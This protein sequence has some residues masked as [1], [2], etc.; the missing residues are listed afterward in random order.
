MK[1]LISQLNAIL[2]LKA[3]TR[4]NGKVASERTKTAIGD[5]LRASFRHLVN[6][7]FRLQNPENLG[8]KHVKALCEFWYQS[9][10]TPKTIQSNLSYLRIFARW[11]GKGEMVKNV[12]H[13]LPDVP[14][15]KLRVKTAAITSKSWAENGIDVREKIREA[16]A[17]DRRFGAMLRVAVAFGLRRHE[18]IECH[19]WKVDRGDRFAAYKTKGGRPRDIYIDTTEQRIVLDQVKSMV[20]KSEHLGWTTKHDGSVADIKFS[21]GKWHRMLAKIGITKAMTK[22][23]GHGLRAQFAENAALIASVIPPTLG[24]GPGQMLKEDLDLRRE[25]AS[26]QLGHSRKSITSAYYGSFGRD[27]GPDPVDRTKNAIAAAVQAIPKEELSPDI[28]SSRLKDC[29]VLT[30]ELMAVKAYVDPRVAHFL[31]EFHSSRHGTD[32]L[33][34]GPQNIAALEAASNHFSSRTSHGSLLAMDQQNAGR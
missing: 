26:E 32:W 19:P 23:T 29:S 9:G 25:Q 10:L 6:L 20:K 15:A 22:V 11:I 21:L 3:G 4:V 7:N 33:S 34:L 14:R 13:Y 2:Q 17:L 16:D 1:S 24:G 30:A 28:P 31:W 18:V 5:S 27:V 12:H 8:D